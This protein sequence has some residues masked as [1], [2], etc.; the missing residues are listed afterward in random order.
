MLFRSVPAAFT[1][2]TTRA[3]WETLVRARAIE[4]G[5]HVIAV[6]QAGTHPDGTTSGGHSL[7][8][9]PWGEVLAVAPEQGDAILTA[10]LDPAAITHAREALPTHR[11]TRPD[12]YTSRATAGTGP[13][14]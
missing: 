4:L 11:L 1:L 13:S 6:N 7:I 14:D 12:A 5:A 3:H 8:V 2:T 10:D 9:S